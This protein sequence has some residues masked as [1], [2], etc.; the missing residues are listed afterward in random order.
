[1]TTLSLALTG[2]I[3]KRFNTRN[4]EQ[5]LADA[6]EAADR[7]LLT[8]TSGFLGLGERG[9]GARHVGLQHSVLTA[10]WCLDFGQGWCLGG[11]QTVR[12]W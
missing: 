4:P 12:C 8:A 3:A 10:R 7:A 2:A 6:F 1:M 9:V 5:A 11:P